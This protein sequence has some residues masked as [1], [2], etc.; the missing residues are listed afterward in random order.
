[1]NA[2]DLGQVITAIESELR[3]SGCTVGYRNMCRRLVNDY[4]LVVSKE[5]VRQ[6]VRLLEPFSPR[7]S[8]TASPFLSPNS[9]CSHLSVLAPLL[10]FMSQS[11]HASHGF[12]SF[13]LP[14]PLRLVSL[15]FAFSTPEPL[16]V[17]GGLAPLYPFCVSPPRFSLPPIFRTPLFVMPVLFVFRSPF[18]PCVSHACH[19]SFSLHLVHVLVLVY[20]H[21]FLFRRYHL[22]SAPPH[23]VTYLSYHSFHSVYT[24]TLIKPPISP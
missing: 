10:R 18:F 1:M 8:A 12:L 2:S 9:I 20:F 24:S 11:I 14:L 16:L 5:T 23:L 3:G 15:G 6:A 21:G 4:H 17:P 7:C 19:S 13:I 22:C